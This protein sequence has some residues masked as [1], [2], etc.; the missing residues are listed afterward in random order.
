M[1]CES[2]LAYYMPQ[3][4]GTQQH[5]SVPVTRIA[6]LVQNARVEMT[7]ML[8]NRDLAL[9]MDVMREFCADVW[10]YHRDTD[11]RALMY[12]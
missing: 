3:V 2:F 12:L 11:V 5:A 7:G 10:V 4:K 8:I 6:T 9:V 1:A